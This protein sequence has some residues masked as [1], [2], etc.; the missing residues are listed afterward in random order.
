MR[1]APQSLI[2]GL[3]NFNS[4]VSTPV[5]TVGSLLDAAPTD[6]LDTTTNTPNW[7]Q[8][9]L[10]YVR[11][12][13]AAAINP[14]RLV[15][16]DHTHNISDLA[17]TANLGQSV[18]VTLSAFAA[19]ST[20]TQYG[21]VLTA[22]IVPVQYAVAATT[23]ALFIGGAGQATP[24]AANGKQILNAR[25]VV[26]ASGSFTRSITT[27]NGS[28]KVTMSRVNGLYLGM[29]VSGTGIPASSVISAIGD[30]GQA[31]TIGSAIGTPVA[32]TAT[33]TVTGTFTHTGYGI[34]QLNR[35]FAQGQVT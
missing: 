5:F 19:G 4:S 29:A 22:G 6:G 31:I 17:N 30:G 16:V 26:A 24:T 28:S 8:C 18:F 10:L 20:T 21:W 3:L 12:T 2:A 32:A 27:V 33:G 15:T 1:L 34:V 23:G 13:G 14:G 7:G 35:P 25:C 11:Y 9:E